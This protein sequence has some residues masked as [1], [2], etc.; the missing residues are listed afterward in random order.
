MKIGS[1]LRKCHGA[2]AWWCKYKLE[3]T[4]HF[5]K[6]FVLGPFLM[7]IVYWCFKSRRYHQMSGLTLLTFSVL[8]CR[9]RKNTFHQILEDQAFPLLLTVADVG[10]IPEGNGSKALLK[11]QNISRLSPPKVACHCPTY[12]RN[13]EARSLI[14]FL[15]LRLCASDPQLSRRIWKL[16]ENNSLSSWATQSFLFHCSCPHPP[17]VV[18]HFPDR[19]EENKRR[20]DGEGQSWLQKLAL[21]RLK[22]KLFQYQ[23]AQITDYREE[24]LLDT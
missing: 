5:G 1:I 15:S 22:A 14:P 16:Q 2:Y 6:W 20:G 10:E 9:E 11:I 21:Q 24:G 17:C 13:M 7:P 8:A 23:T 4:F 19:E 3:Q 12:N 18:R